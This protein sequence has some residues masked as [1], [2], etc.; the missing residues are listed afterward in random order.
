MFF[1]AFDQKWIL[2]TWNEIEMLIICLSKKY[3]NEKKK[4][5]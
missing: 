3:N 1:F 4:E 5:K 2:R